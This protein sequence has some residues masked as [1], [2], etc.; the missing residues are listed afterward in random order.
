MPFAQV[1]SEEV[2]LAGGMDLVTPA[3]ATAPGVLIDSVNYEP[4]ING[5]Y[6]RMYGFERIDGRPSPSQQ[7]YWDM[8]VALTHSVAVGATV[9][10]A[11]SG[12]TAVVLQV[13]GITELIVTKVVG[14]FQAETITVSASSVGTVS[15]V[16]QASALTPLLDAAYTALAA[17]NYRADIGHPPGSGP[18]RG[19]K[20]YN[21]SLYAFR[22]NSGNTAC[23]M[24][25]ATT[26]G[27]TA[28]TFGREIQF[29][30]AVGQINVGDTVT[31]ATSGATGVVKAALLRT[32][33]WTVSGVGT[34]V[35]D[36]VT[37]AF[38]NAEALQV[39]TV[40]KATSSTVDTAIALQP[41]GR[42]EFINYN[43]SGQATSLKMYGCDGVNFMFEFD[44]TRLVPI[45]TGISGDNP[46]FITAWENMLVA[47]LGSSVE[48]SGIGQQ[49]SWTALT[50]A[51]ELTLGDTCTGL[52]PQVG[53]GTQ[54][55]LAIFTPH[56]TFI[57]YGTSEADFTLVI[58][59]PD[60]GA[61]PYSCQNVGF[62]YFLDT[63]GMLQI[64]TSRNYGNFAMS[65]LTRKIQ[66]II[67]AKRGLAVASCIVR[68]SNQIRIY[69]AD[70]TGFILYMTPQNTE[71]VGGDVLLGDVVG[72]AMYFDMGSARY[73][74]TITSDI[75]QFGIERTFAAGSDGYVYEL[76]RGTSFD[77]AAI[78][79]HLFTCF[80][81]SKS[82]RNRKHYIRTVLM[83]QCGNTANVNVGYE[84]S[85]GGQETNS[86]YQAFQTLIG[87]G[88]WWD[89][90]TFDSFIWDAPYVNEYVIDTP[91]N[92]RNLSLMV[93]GNTNL[94]L[95]YTVQ[96]AIMNYT[97]GRLER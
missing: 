72:G 23:V 56:K 36:T 60:A 55:A 13:N 43:F 80:N 2:D 32:G 69:Y 33:T 9:T 84:L 1:Q 51:A 35:F 8:V 45:R 21:G 16:N 6:R 88:S 64:N 57:L 91:G 83:A 49:Y 7:T 81:S 61:A 67:N 70:G 31:G 65:V 30:N 79:S 77:G 19:V 94:D 82:P 27:W 10:G 73:F 71:S 52:L 47:A 14:T 34:L 12:A 87:N 3:L 39:A 28:I 58:Q 78:Q 76:E 66:P 20:Y 41:N 42:F 37:G 29:T 44:G 74:Y 46:Q 40:T 92:G 24:Y 22:N 4:N 53:N 26:S 97:I 89:I 90:F 25:R 86:G 59:S 5:G 11:T 93:Y 68:A 17:D 54:G 62:A 95:P 75:D 50:G 63:K 96:S 15:Q 38:Q 18:T 48:V 85:Y